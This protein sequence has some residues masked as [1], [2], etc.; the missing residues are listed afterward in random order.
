MRQDFPKTWVHARRKG[1]SGFSTCGFIGG[2]T[3]PLSLVLG[4]IGWWQMLHLRSD[5]GRDWSS[6][7]VMMF[8]IVWIVGIEM[9][10]PLFVLD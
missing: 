4:C 8:E 7:S 3:S 9:V 1:V 2:S 10:Q 6:T 5:G